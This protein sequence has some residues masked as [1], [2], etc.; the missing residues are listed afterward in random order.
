MIYNIGECDHQRNWLVLLLIVD[1]YVPNKQY[2]Y[3]VT[4]KVQRFSGVE[5]CVTQIFDRP[6]R[7]KIHIY[8]KVDASCINPSANNYIVYT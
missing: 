2:K 3:V 7:H 8:V 5:T 6:I 4:S 1:K